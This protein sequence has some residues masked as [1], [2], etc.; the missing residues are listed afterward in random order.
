MRIFLFLI[1]SVHIIFSLDSYAEIKETQNILRISAENICFD[2]SKATGHL[3]DIEVCGRKYAGSGRAFVSDVTL[4]REKAASGSSE[5]TNSQINLLGISAEDLDNLYEVYSS[6]SAHVSSIRIA[7]IRDDNYLFKIVFKKDCPSYGMVR[8]YLDRDNNPK[9]G[10]EGEGMDYLMV[11]QEGDR[12][13]YCYTY[14]WTQQGERKSEHRKAAAVIKGN[15]M[16]LTFKIEFLKNEEKASGSLFIITDTTKTVMKPFSFSIKLT[17]KQSSELLVPVNFILKDNKLTFKQETDSKKI[18]VISE[19]TTEH[20]YIKWKITVK[21]NSRIERNCNIG[22]E[23]P[24]YYESNWYYWDGFAPGAISNTTTGKTY[25]GISSTFPLGCV[26]SGGEGIAAGLSP[27][28]L[29]CSIENGVSK[30]SDKP[31]K[32]RYGIRAAIIPGGKATITIIIFGF[33]EKY[34]YLDA[35]EKYYDFFPQ[36]FSPADG[37]NPYLRGMGLGALHWRY[38]YR[39]DLPDYS[40]DLIRRLSYGKGGWEWGYTYDFPGDWGLT[41]TLKYNQ[42]KR[43]IK[44]FKERYD[45]AERNMTAIAYYTNPHWC[46]QSIVKKEFTDSIFDLGPFP[47]SD[48][49]THQWRGETITTTKL[50]SVGNSWGDNLVSSTKNIIKT[51]SPSAIG[52]DS[53][54]GFVK[55]YGKASRNSPARAFDDQGRSYSIEGIGYSKLMDLAHSLTNSRGERVGAVTN[56]KLAGVFSDAFR[57]DAILHEGTPPQYNTGDKYE[58]FMRLRLLTGKKT[59]AWY[60]AIIPE[61]WINWEKLTP[62][63]TLDTL[64]YIRDEIL[65]C[66]VHFGALPSTRLVSGVEKFYLNLPLLQ[67]LAVSGWRP[68]PKSSVGENKL[69]LSRF[70]DEFGGYYSIVNMHKEDFSSQFSTDSVDG[71]SVILADVNGQE[72]KNRITQQGTIANFTLKKQCFKVYEKAALLSGL[73]PDATVNTCYVN[74]EFKKKILRMRIN[75]PNASLECISAVPE[76]Y[77]PAKVAVMGNPVK[78]SYEKETG[79]IRYNFRCGTGTTDVEVVYNRCINIIGNLQDLYDIDFFGME[80]ADIIIIKN[81]IHDKNYQYPAWRI[82]EY[83]RFYSKEVLGMDGAVVIPVKDK[84]GSVKKRVKIILKPVKLKGD[85]S[86]RIKISKNRITISGSQE[87]LLKAVLRFLSIL[88]KKYPY[89][90]KFMLEEGIPDY[91]GRKKAPAGSVAEKAGLSNYI[92]KGEIGEP[93][94]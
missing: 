63:E 68:S 46:E 18:S 39:E 12:K 3:Q 2:L 87:T 58:R 80:S 75:C 64:R 79:L 25:T 37:T 71:R 23:F 56:L 21:N 69:L 14:Y 72:V 9:T 55:D 82:Q 45:S 70:G 43:H 50:F 5:L 24:F 33:H 6:P 40:G 78:F 7:N 89:Y 10:R 65:L 86:A 60:N 36:A 52:Y 47:N 57:S 35:L 1:F 27:D 94:N 54:S 51:Y 20:K 28:D 88:D 48:F 74:T 61:R 67:R 4:S 41:H 22:I 93:L 76:E 91:L 62:Q 83:F 73:R 30:I 34:G 17:G 42:S 66:S 85:V 38:S 29:V 15:I 90:G 81:N 16:Y 44:I 26:Y 19:I 84:E 92:L 77:Y 53:A 32:F 59:I 13:P 31:W 8:M 11:A 49:L